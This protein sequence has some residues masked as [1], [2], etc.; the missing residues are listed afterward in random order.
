MSSLQVEACPSDKDGTT[1]R[2][3]EK[4]GLRHCNIDTTLA[5]QYT[6]R[7]AMLRCF[8]LPRA[9]FASAVGIGNASVCSIRFIAC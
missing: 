6:V 9:S 3:F 4:V 1:K 2:Y 7:V 5:G 8:S